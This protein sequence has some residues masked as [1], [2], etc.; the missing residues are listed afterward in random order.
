MKKCPFNISKKKMKKYTFFN[1]NEKKILFHS[2]HVV[3]TF[4]TEKQFI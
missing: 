1:K 4:K 3:M 2:W